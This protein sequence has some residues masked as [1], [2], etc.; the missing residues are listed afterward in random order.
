MIRRLLPVLLMLFGTAAEGRPPKGQPR[1]R[2]LAKRPAQ[3][4]GFNFDIDDNI[5]RMPTKLWV[6]D[7]RPGMNGKES[8]MS[9]AEWALVRSEFAPSKDGKYLQ[10]KGDYRHYTVDLD[11]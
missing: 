9:T 1:V 10:G 2:V 5:V 4:V 11:P 7:N 8:G 3:V 6:R